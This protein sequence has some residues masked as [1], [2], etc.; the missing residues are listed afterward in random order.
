MDDDFKYMHSYDYIE[1]RGKRVGPQVLPTL[2][3]A[4]PLELVNV[5]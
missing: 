2:V 4:L 3:T 1:I 5:R